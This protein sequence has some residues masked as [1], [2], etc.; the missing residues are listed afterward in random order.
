MFADKSLK[1]MRTMTGMTQE[2]FADK[3]LIPRRT[4]QNWE[5]NESKA[6][7]QARKTPIYIKYMIR[8]ILTYEEKE[9]SAQNTH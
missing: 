4:Y 6:N 1:E 3:F 7:T 2:Q 5:Y 8:T 9:K